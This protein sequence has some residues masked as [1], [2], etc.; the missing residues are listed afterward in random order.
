MKWAILNKEMSKTNMK[1]KGGV[2]TEQPKIIIT[3]KNFY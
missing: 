1:N 3:K 2:G